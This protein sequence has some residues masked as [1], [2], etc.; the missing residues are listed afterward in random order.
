MGRPTARRALRVLLAIFSGVSLS[1]ADPVV[2]RSPSLKQAQAASKAIFVLI[3]P[4]WHGAWCW[5]K[6][7]PLLRSRGHDVYAPT[8]TGLGERAHL[9]HPM[10]G[11]ETHV[12]DV[13]NVLD[14][15]DL[16]D[17]ILVGHSNAGTLITAVADRVP[18]RLA[19]LVYL[20]AFVPKDGQ[21][22]IDLI[23][24]P[25]Q[26]WE[27]RVRTEGHGWLIPSLQPVPWDEFVRDVWRVT[28]ET[29]RRWMVA[30]LG[31]TPFKTFTDP[32]RR[33][34]P[35]AEK[36]PRTYIRC[37]QHPSAAFDRYAEMARQTAGWRYRELATAHEAF[38]TM[39]H[40][41]AG[42]LLEI[43]P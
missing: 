37:R 3:H 38:V 25:R 23:T 2:A 7:I 16:R 43:V 19:H 28:D 30:R 24:F 34:N 22:T 11:L 1:S 41:L 29:D 10:V 32:V 4:A 21:A 33:K 42:L 39:P 15:E 17:V 26:A 8:L 13:V 6:V 27:A 12:Q 36:L 18:D 9:A 31:P 35:A 14:Y 40:E 20:D 5:K